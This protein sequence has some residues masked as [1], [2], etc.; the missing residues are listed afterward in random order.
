MQKISNFPYA[1]LSNLFHIEILN[2]FSIEGDL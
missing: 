2:G 1:D